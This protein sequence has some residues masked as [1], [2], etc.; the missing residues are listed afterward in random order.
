MTTNGD[1]LAR[2]DVFDDGTPAPP[3]ARFLPAAKEA[4]AAAPETLRAEVL[5]LEAE[6]TAGLKK[7]Q[8]AAARDASL[9]EFHELAAKGGTTVKEALCK[10]VNLEN[11]LRTDPIR[12]L[13]IICQ[14]VGLSLR[15]V[16]ALLRVTPGPDSTH[17]SVAEFAATHPRFDDLS[18]DIIFLLETG[19]A[20]DLPEAY[21]LAERLNR[22]PSEAD[23]VESGKRA[24]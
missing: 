21:I 11:Q 12:G 10:Y 23:E 20:N 17:D 5:R 9:A 2:I 18:E 14:N 22:T 15:D 16:A 24:N 4:W 8:A 1:A 7:H 6:L 3:P 19:R 13:E